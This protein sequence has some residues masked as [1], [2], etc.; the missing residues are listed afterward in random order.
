MKRKEN[1]PA[2]KKNDTAA[3]CGLATYAISCEC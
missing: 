1:G 2:R 3:T